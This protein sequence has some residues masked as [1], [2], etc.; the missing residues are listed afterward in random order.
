ML[1]PEAAQLLPASVPAPSLSETGDSMK[2][3]KI[4]DFKN[5]SF[6]RDQVQR[7][8]WCSKKY[9]SGTFCCVTKNRNQDKSVVTAVLEPILINSW[10]QVSLTY[11]QITV[12]TQP[13][14]KLFNQR[15][16]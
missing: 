15:H 9:V 14:N 8:W 10:F 12:L 3:F 7:W 16:V 11:Q 4:I 2:Y 1:Q 13:A 6:D 5:F